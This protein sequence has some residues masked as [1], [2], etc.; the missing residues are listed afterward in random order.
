[1]QDAHERG[2]WERATPAYEAYGKGIGERATLAYEAYERGLQQ[3][4]RRM[5]EA[6]Y[7]IAY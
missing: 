2:L 7:S 4:M 6:M 3:H 5:K 1:M